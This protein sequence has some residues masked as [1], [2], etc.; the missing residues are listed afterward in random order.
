[1]KAPDANISQKPLDFLFTA[2]SNGV[3]DQIDGLLERNLTVWPKAG[4]VSFNLE[5]R[6]RIH[7]AV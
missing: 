3:A 4:V 5:V 2:E 6:R 1:M 7:E